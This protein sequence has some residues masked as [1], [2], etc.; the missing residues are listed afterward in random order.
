MSGHGFHVHGPHDHAVEHVAQGAGHGDSFSNNIAVMTA[1]L[2]TVGALFGYLGGA[3]Q[4]DAALFKNNA[5]IAK[6]TAANAWNYYQ[7]KSNKQNLAELAAELPGVDPAKYKAE[8]A[9]YETEKGGIRKDAEQHE[10]ESDAWNEKSERALHSHHQWALATTAEQIAISLAA[11]ALL[12]RRRWLLRVT[13]VVAIVGFV[14]GAFAGLHI[15]PIG[16][17]TAAGPATHQIAH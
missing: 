13:Y 1:V 3:T 11:I 17:L 8:V 15:D 16:A 14:L 6:T 12:T 9:R 2:A 10:R 5:A 4:N 7:A